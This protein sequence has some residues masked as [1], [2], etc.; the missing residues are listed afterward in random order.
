MNH[1]LLCVFDMC[2]DF[3]EKMNFGEKCLVPNI[4]DS[5]RIK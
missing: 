5:L 3:K 1:I 4:P 2:D